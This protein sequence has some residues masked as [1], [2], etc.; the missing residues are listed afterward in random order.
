L[1]KSLKA[2]NEDAPRWLTL[3]RVPPPEP[4]FELAQKEAI[5]SCKDL[6]D[7]VS[8]LFKQQTDYF[9]VHN[10]EKGQERVEPK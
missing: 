3:L 8:A 4:G 2:L 9:A 6:N 1:R 10:D 7:Q 5:E